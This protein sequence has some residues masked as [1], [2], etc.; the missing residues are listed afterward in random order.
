MNPYQV[1]LMT[2]KLDY[3]LS[4]NIINLNR[5]QCSSW[6]LAHQMFTNA[7]PKKKEV[8]R[9]SKRKSTWLDKKHDAKKESKHKVLGRG[10]LLNNNSAFN[11]IIL[12]INYHNLPIFFHYKIK[13]VGGRGM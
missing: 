4:Y 9:I 3:Y 12:S 8:T 2:V 11:A 7:R 13:E 1:V 5:R 6:L 10:V